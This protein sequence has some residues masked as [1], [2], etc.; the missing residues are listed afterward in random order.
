MPSQLVLCWGYNHYGQLGN[1]SNTLS[2]VPTPVVTLPPA[3]S[4]AAGDFH[5]C[6]ID[7]SNQAW[8]WGSNQYGALG[9]GKTADKN[10]PVAV[11]GEFQFM[12]IAAGGIEGTSSP[13]DFSCGITTRG[14]VYCW[15]YN[16]NGQLGN[17][18]TTNSSVPV[19]VSGLPGTATQIAAGGEHAC[20]VLTAGTVYCW[21]LNSHGQLGNNKNKQSTTAV[22]ALGLS[23]ATAIGAGTFDSCAL[24]SADK[25]FCWGD[26]SEG[27]IGDASTTDAHTP[28]QVQSLLGPVQAI[29]VNGYHNCAIVPASGQTEIQ[30]WGDGLDGGLGD[31]RMQEN[32]VTLP[33]AVFGLIGSPASGLGV[34][35]VQIA[36]GQNHTCAA[37][38]TGQIYCWGA[39]QKG[40]VGD[41]TQ[42][43]RDVPTLVLGITGNIQ[44]VTQGSDGGCA[45]TGSLSVDCWGDADG[46][47][48]SAHDTAQAVTS[49]T[50]G[51]ASVSASSG[52]GCALSISGSLVCW[53]LNDAG[54]VG[55]GTTTP[56]PTPVGVNGMSSGVGAVAEGLDVTCANVTSN[57]Q[58]FCWGSNDDGQLGDGTT[59][60]RRSPVQVGLLGWP[61]TVTED[62]GCAISTN[63]HTFC[64]GKNGYGQLGNGNTN[65]SD[66]PVK[67]KGLP[68]PAVQVT[69]GAGFNGSDI[70]GFS[71]ALVTD[72]SVHC[73]G[74]GGDGQL[75][76]GLST[77]SN[78]PV[79]VQLSAPA[80]EVVSGA[81]S[82]CAL[83]VTGTVQCWGADTAGELGDGGS[84]FEGS[85]VNVS[86]LSGVIQI[87]GDGGYGACALTAS[88][89]VSCWGDNSQDELGDG[90]SGGM[91][92]TPQ[93]VMGL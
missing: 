28:Q 79:T 15:G 76:N 12:A 53:G 90:Q 92:N 93:L 55:N 14:A 59:K 54:Q 67:V 75:G 64:W 33:E 58:L 19:L 9:N 7:T 45:I 66:T 25:M 74:F 11:S 26:N 70:G 69:T 51:I 8:C 41:G 30:C 44:M 48:L 17:G 65:D 61:A 89:S 38:L 78:S 57:N 29:A 35:P 18:T 86:G 21:G 88:G 56:E 52:G 24:T 31:G 32:P 77:S 68:F 27:E 82:A 83:L 71:C 23:N 36:A 85:P 81:Y 16:G 2:T 46:N 13:A 6:A 43:N 87:S 72:G 63:T 37:V 49:L 91:S 80:K 84:G 42:G 40:Q 62:H 20:A 39:N 4:V 34:T 60:D 73:W 50:G 3:L 22:L 1:G 10:K 5:T 47:D